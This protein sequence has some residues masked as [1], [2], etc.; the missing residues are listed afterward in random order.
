MAQVETLAQLQE[1]LGSRQSP[2][3]VTADIEVRERLYIEYELTLESA[4]GLFTLSKRQD[5]N[6]YMLR[7]R[8]GGDLTLQNIVLDGSRAGSYVENPNNRSLVLAE[9]GTVRLKSGAVLQNN[10]SYQEGGGVYLSGDPSY[11]NHFFMEGNARITGCASRSSGGGFMAALRNPADSVSISGQ[12]MVDGNTA[13]NGGGI[14]VRPYVAGVENRLTIGGGVTITGNSAQNAGGGVYF[15]GYRGSGSLS[16]QL[17]LAGG[18]MVRGNTAVNGAGIWFYGADPD[19]GDLL[20]IGGRAAVA[21]NTASGNGGGVWMNSSP[22]G[23]EFQMTGGSLDDNEGGTGGGLYYLTAGGGA[24]GISSGRVS[25]NKATNGAGGSGGGLWILNSSSAAPAVL[26]FLSSD[27]GHNEASAHGGGMYFA[28]G[29]SSYS[30]RVSDTSFHDN[31][32][33]LNGGGIVL[34]APAGGTA[35]LSESGFS[36][37]SSGG[38]GGAIYYANTGSAASSVS[39]R[40]VLI[41]DNTADNEGGGLR[42]SSGGG[43]FSGTLTDCTV[44]GNRARE[45]DGG[46]IWVGGGNASVRL[47]GTTEV[48]E[49]STEAGNGGGVYLN[50]ANGIL[51]LEDDAKISFNRADERADDT[52][53]KGGGISV[54]PGTVII[55]D[56]AEIAGNS[57]LKYGGGISASER[58]SIEMSG[59]SIH[60]NTAGLQGGGVWNHSGSALTVTGG[61]LYSNASRDGGGIYNDIGS[62]LTIEQDGTVGEAGKN[63]ADR[64]APG[65]YNGGMLYLEGAQELENGLYIEDRGAVANLQGPVGGGGDGA[66]AIQIDSSNY[67]KPNPEGTPIVVAEATPR[68]PR[69]GQSDAEAFRKPPEGFEGW[70]VRLSEDGTQVVLAPVNYTIRYENLKGADHVNPLTYTVTS[71]D[72]VLAD[73]EEVPGYRFLGWYDAAEGGNRVTVIPAGSM[74]DLTLYARW[75]A[76]RPDVPPTEVRWCCCPCGF[77]RH[78]KL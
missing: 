13:D 3:Q 14:Y 38:S 45:S 49:N 77:G 61:D 6:A 24:V 34:N 27:I 41:T 47:A 73:P 54:I 33:G 2:I 36:Q 29:P 58:S 52:G 40:Q 32:A 66:S 7:V 46:G 25:G 20:A 4:G 42:L 74:G 37:N 57:A 48:K 21:G 17:S 5:F 16:A 60:G 51:T 63:T 12:A 76:E 8:N 10:S 65:V 70:E 62:T 35:D 19:S 23:M 28:A 53:N 56:R 64:R 26:N 39:L 78:M 18:V 67:V 22:G 9:G 15:S 50:S 55:R 30:M 59:G 44:S 69:L 68:Y 11:V 72:I 31:I 71:P 1:A 43:A 75:E